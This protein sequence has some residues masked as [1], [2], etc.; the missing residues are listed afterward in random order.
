M[1]SRKNL[2]ALV[3]VSLC[4]AYILAFPSG[5]LD[6]ASISD[7]IN[8]LDDSPWPCSP[9]VENAQNLT[10][11]VLRPSF[12]RTVREGIIRVQRIFDPPPKLYL[13]LATPRADKTDFMLR[14]SFHSSEHGLIQ[15]QSGASWGSWLD[16]TVFG[17]GIKVPSDLDP[18]DWGDLELQFDM[19]VRKIELAGYGDWW[20]VRLTHP[21]FPIHGRPLQRYW[22]FSL[23]MRRPG[24]PRAVG[25]GDIDRTVM[26]LEAANED[27]ENCGP[28]ID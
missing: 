10:V 9:K 22:D 13:V 17:K 20:K 11:P 12:Q 21:S 23:R 15:I 4:L 16:P 7:A 6:A 25:I 1:Q 8:S 19:A 18:F 24:D 26:L 14:L 28:G 27:V 2:I 5:T 3:C